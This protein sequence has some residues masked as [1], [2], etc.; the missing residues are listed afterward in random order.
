MEQK[1]GRVFEPLHSSCLQRYNFKRIFAPWQKLG[2][3]ASTKSA[4][5]EEDN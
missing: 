3:E 4:Y 1:K 5:S 2:T